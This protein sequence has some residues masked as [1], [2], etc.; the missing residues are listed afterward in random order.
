MGSQAGIGYPQY[1]LGPIHDAFG[2][3]ESQKF[4][5]IADEE[6]LLQVIF[7]TVSSSHFSTVFRY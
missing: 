2:E 1:S 4:E 7:S 3:D 6:A 5:L